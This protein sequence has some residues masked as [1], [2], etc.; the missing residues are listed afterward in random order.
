MSTDATTLLVTIEAA[1]VKLEKQWAD[2]LRPVL[3]EFTHVQ[4]LERSQST[5]DGQ[6]AFVDARHPQLSEVLS[7]ID[8]TGRSVLLLYSEGDPIP[9]A[10]TDGRVDDVLVFPL[11]PLEVL[12]KIRQHEQ[13]RLW[14]QVSK[15]STALGGVM[16]RLRE[17]MAVAERLQKAR[18]P[19]RFPE[20]KG[21]KVT[22]RYLAGLKSGGDYFDLAESA[23]GRQLAM[24][25]TDS[26]SYG[27]SSAV[28]SGVVRVASRLSVEQ[29]RSVRELVRAFYEELLVPL[30]PTDRLSLF[31]GVLSRKDYVLRYLNLGDSRAFFRPAGKSFTV[32]PAQGG[33]LSLGSRH[34][35][36][37]SGVLQEAQLQLAP[38]DRVVL[39]SDGYL[40]LLGGEHRACA[41]LEQFSSRAPEDLLNELAFQTK[42]RLSDP[43]EDLP[44][45]DSSAL[46]FDVDSKVMR[47]V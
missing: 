47:L 5:E 9:A 2:L 24:I 36:G 11:R 27:L 16:E 28:V 22:S 31:Y 8:R 26:S 29:A 21:F 15:M 44:A 3:R 32:L 25:L 30:G 40:E 14:D 13:S 45:Q 6:M 12:S 41:L 1:S 34:S 39:L 17:D 43:R 10:F 4:I 23:D 7:G 46:V 42:S 18:L 35:L 38:Q 33:P 37:Q 19:V 20:I